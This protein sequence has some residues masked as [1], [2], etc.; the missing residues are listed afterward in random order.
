[1]NALKGVSIG[2]VICDGDRVW[3]FSLSDDD[4]RTGAAIIRFIKAIHYDEFVC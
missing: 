4:C 1:M 3:A 2:Y